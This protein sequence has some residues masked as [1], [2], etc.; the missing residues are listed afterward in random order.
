M[1]EGAKGAVEGEGCVGLGVVSCRGKGRPVG[2][3]S[4]EGLLT[5]S[6]GLCRVE[7]NAGLAAGQIKNKRVYSSI[8]SKT[9]D[10][11]QPPLF[12]DVY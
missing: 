2:S 3:A 10:C 11:G 8:F 12:I 5:C 6:R 1:G 7:L 9:P 4:L